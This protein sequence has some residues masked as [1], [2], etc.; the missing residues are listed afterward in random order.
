MTRADKLRK[1]S[2]QIVEAG[3]EDDRTSRQ[4]DFLIL[5]LIVASTIATTLESVSA[6]REN[7][8]SVFLWFERF[9]IGV[10][11]AEYVVRS[12]ACVEDPK[13][14]HP[15]WG[16]LRFAMTPLQLV[17]L[18]AV[19]PFYLHGFVD[20]RVLRLLRL[21][22]IFRLAKL[23]RYWQSLQIIQRVFSRCMADLW[24]TVA[25]ILILLI[26]ASTLMY[27]VEHDAQPEVFSNIPAAMWWGIE[28]ITTVG[29]GEIVPITALGKV[30]ASFVS[31]L[32]IAVIALPTAILGAAFTDEIDKLKSATA[33]PHCG[34]R[35]DAQ[36]DPLPDDDA[37]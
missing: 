33:C 9:T 12:W 16:R 25:V 21:V 20:L 26:V 30:I 1:R 31:L 18:A 22:R 6:I 8:L 37:E 23:T 4:F 15:F 27:A 29:Y 2:W 17:D 3:T 7:A 19:L 10:F 13:Y 32:G 24:V 28:T 35:I 14:R 34:K 11:T 5:G 36:A